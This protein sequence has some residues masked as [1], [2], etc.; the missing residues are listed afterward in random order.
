MKTT[1]ITIDTYKDTGLGDAANDLGLNM[2]DLFEHGEF[3][4][5]TIIV[6]EN[7]N[8]IGGKLVPHKTPVRKA[9]E[10]TEEE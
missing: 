3:M 7:L 10:E 1:E 8:I 2:Y 9:E 6:D 4:N 5:A